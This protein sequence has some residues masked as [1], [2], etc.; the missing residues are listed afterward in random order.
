MPAT[1]SDCSYMRCEQQLGVY[2]KQQQCPLN[3]HKTVSYVT[4]VY[5]RCDILYRSAVR[6]DNKKPMYDTQ[7]S[8]CSFLLLIYTLRFLLR[9][10]F[11][12]KI[13]KVNFVI[14]CVATLY[15]PLISITLSAH[16]PHGLELS[17]QKQKGDENEMKIR[18][19]RTEIGKIKYK[20]IISVRRINIHKK[21]RK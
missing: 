20:F 12:M 7:F 13:I 14:E 4:S 10:F 19:K 16:T 6:R 5:Q 18:I 3:I 15:A 21:H 1:D 17:R 8:I 11:R 9:F 2:E